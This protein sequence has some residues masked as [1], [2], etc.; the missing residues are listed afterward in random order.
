[1]LFVLGLDDRAVSEAPRVSVKVD[2]TEV[3]DLEPW[4][5]E[6]GELMETW[7]PKIATYLASD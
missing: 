2:A 7:Y 5:K 3:P 4:A 6:G 1:M